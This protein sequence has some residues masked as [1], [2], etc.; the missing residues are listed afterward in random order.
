MGAQIPIRIAH[1]WE[2]SELYPI[3]GAATKTQN[4]RIMHKYIAKYQRFGFDFAITM[5][6]LTLRV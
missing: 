1:A 6:R 5:H 4:D 2:A 3:L